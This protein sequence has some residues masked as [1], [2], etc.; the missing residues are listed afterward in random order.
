MT[1]GRLKLNSK[2]DWSNYPNFTRDEFKCSHTGKCEMDSEFMDT[3]QAIRYEYGK[4]MIITSGYRHYTHPIEAAK[5]HKNGEH[6]QGRCCDVSV[7]GEDAYNL[8]RIAMK[9]GITRIGVNQKGGGR[10]LHLGMGGQN[11]PNPWIWSY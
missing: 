3:L 5:G 11:L 8:I 2:V 9:H 7:R 6:V 1:N 4:P 10:F